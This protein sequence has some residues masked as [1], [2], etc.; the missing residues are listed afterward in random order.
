MTRGLASVRCRRPALLWIRRVTT[1]GGRARRPHHTAL[2]I[3]ALVLLT[4][5][6]TARSEF[7]VPRRDDW[8]RSVASALRD[9]DTWI[10][11]A[12]AVAFAVAGVDEDVSDWAREQT[13]VFGSTHRAETASDAL[14]GASH[15]LMFAA[16]FPPRGTEDRWTAFAVTALEEEAIVAAVGAV[17]LGAKNAADRE[18]PDASNRASFPSGH[19]SGS[20]ATGALA[21]ERLARSAIPPRWHPAVRIG[22]RAI[23]GATA[24]ARIE[25]GKHYPTDVLAGSALGHLLAVTLDRAVRDGTEVEVSIAPSREGIF[26]DARVRF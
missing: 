13:P 12:A 5:C 8:K 6:A 4:G 20:A 3:A 10:P 11:A 1:E 24:W 26:F 25:A 23:H 21:R 18:R 9:P 7:D 16:A 22:S 2:A 19:S 14:K 15:L 17:T